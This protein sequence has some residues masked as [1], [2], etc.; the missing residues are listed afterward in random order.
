MY[1][2]HIKDIIKRITILRVIYRI[3]RNCYLDILMIKNYLT[4]KKKIGQPIKV[5]FIC[6]YIP[7]WNKIESLYLLM[8]SDSRFETILLCV[9]SEIENNKLLNYECGKND[10]YEYF[11]NNNYSEAVNSLCK[12]NKWLDIRKMNPTYV[13]IQRPYNTYMPKPY[14]SRE[15][16]K[17]SKVCMIMYGM[18]LSNLYKNVSLN[19]DFF[20]F[21]SY[22]FAETEYT[23]QL[24]YEKN[25]L[26]HKLGIQKSY[27]FGTPVI[28]SIMKKKGISSDSWDFSKNSFRVMWTPRWTTDLSLGGTN[29][30]DFYKDMLDF[31]VNHSDIDFL[32]RPHPLMFDNFIKTGEMKKRE[33][34]EFKHICMEIENVN[35]D[36]NKTYDA[37]FWGTDVLVTDI[38]GIMYEFL[39]T[40]K[41]MIFC[42]SNMSLE[43]TKDAEKMLKGC[44]IVENIKELFECL[45]E[46]KKGYD[47]LMN[48]R[49]RIIKELFGDIN[50]SVS[51][52]IL[53]ELVAENVDKKTRVKRR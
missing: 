45:L 37:T 14:T 50:S 8:K 21:V 7:A 5:I 28:E 22:Y 33:V 4:K 9:P 24:N 51:S 17:F 19:K 42:K 13:F 18:G 53:D 49:K 27:F 23:L 10:T 46:L 34:D 11:V 44:Y 29:F 16:S 41:P 20:S 25:K 48:I 15:V 3:Y 1:K 6:Q 40:G 30:L 32:F 43:L 26:A 38:S 47:P 39:A 2:F 35:L 52:K 31:A 12:G 36:N